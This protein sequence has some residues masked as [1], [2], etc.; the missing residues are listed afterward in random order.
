[1]EDDLK[2]REEDLEDDI[3]RAKERFKDDKADVDR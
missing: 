2:Q 1:M 3:K